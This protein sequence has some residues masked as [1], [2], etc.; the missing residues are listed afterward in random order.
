MKYAKK[1]LNT[2]IIMIIE[3]NSKEGFY[4]CT[5]TFMWLTGP[6]HRTRCGSFSQH[7]HHS[8]SR[9]VDGRAFDPF[10]FFRLNAVNCSQIVSNCKYS[11]TIRLIIHLWTSG[12]YAHR[13]ES[14]FGIIFPRINAAKLSKMLQLKL[15]DLYTLALNYFGQISS[16]LLIFFTTWNSF[17]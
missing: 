17:S 15:I 3:K 4:T 6:P 11:C 14:F 8:A 16:I 5:N 1:I 2:R 12:N 9:G 7:T 10:L 13:Y